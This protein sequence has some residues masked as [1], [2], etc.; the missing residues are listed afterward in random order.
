MPWKSKSKTQLYYTISSLKWKGYDD[1][2]S[3]D[4]EHDDPWVFKGCV[5]FLSPRM[6]NIQVI[7]S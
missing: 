1:L 4:R 6:I 3:T 5:T 2:F 7:L